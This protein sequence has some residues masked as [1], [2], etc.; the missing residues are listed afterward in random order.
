MT[1][2][3]DIICF[4]RYAFGHNFQLNRSPRQYCHILNQMYSVES[5]F[6][7][8]NLIFIL[9]NHFSIIPLSPFE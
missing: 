3:L 7:V 6:E 5:G 8:S 2:T 1:H 4:S 9:L